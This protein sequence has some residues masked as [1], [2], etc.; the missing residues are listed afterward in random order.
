MRVRSEP[1]QAAVPISS[2]TDSTPIELTQRGCQCEDRD[3]R[4]Y[5]DEAISNPLVPGSCQGGMHDMTI[6]RFH[7][8]RGG[9]TYSL[10]L[11]MLTTYDLS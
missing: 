11:L 9:Y 3:K 5:I 6:V 7:E 8:P 2:P 4:R 10:R 1:R